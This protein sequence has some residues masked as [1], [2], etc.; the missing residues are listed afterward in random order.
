[1]LYRWLVG[2]RCERQSPVVANPISE[3]VSERL[4]NA[5]R[6]DIVLGNLAPGVRLRVDELSKRYGISHIPVREALLHLA[7]ERLVV[8]EPHKGAILRPVTPNF[9]A[10]IHDTRAAIAGVLVRRATQRIT[11]EELKTLDRLCG[12]HEIAAAT[13]VAED[14]SAANKAFHSF[15]AQVADNPEASYI[16]DQGW[17][18]VISLRFRFGLSPDRVKEIVSQHRDIVEAIRS[19]DPERAMLAVKE[20][21][22]SAKEDL[23]SRME[24]ERQLLTTG[25]EAVPAPVLDI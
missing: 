2:T 20:H 15:I 1:M 19:R 16:L 7:G 25:G 3:T 4:L 6:R 9:V 23:L 12:Q 10:D 5:I 24:N 21:C 17:E 13:G 14:M 18:L 22:D 8:L 11:D